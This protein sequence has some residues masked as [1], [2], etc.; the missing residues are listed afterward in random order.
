MQSLHYVTLLEELRAKLL[1][2][3]KSASESGLSG[4]QVT[5]DR[6]SDPEEPKLSWSNTARDSIASASGVYR[7]EGK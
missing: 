5:Q 3:A 6:S 4:G 1:A 7:A 2:H